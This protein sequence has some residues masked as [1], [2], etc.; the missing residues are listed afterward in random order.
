MLAA[1]TLPVGTLNRAGW[2]SVRLQA[3]P[4]TPTL[5]QAFDNV[6]ITTTADASAGNYD[7]IG[8]LVLRVRAR[9]RRAVAWPVATA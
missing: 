5:E 6:G 9:R 1:I 8:G 7:G 2:I 3:A 4:D